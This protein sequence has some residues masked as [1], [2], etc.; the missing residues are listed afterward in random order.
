MEFGALPLAVP[1]M[2]NHEDLD[3]VARLRT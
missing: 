2:H 3:H 1:F